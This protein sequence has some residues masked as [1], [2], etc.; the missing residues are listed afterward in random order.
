MLSSS[1]SLSAALFEKKSL[2]LSKKMLTF[3]YI[4]SEIPPSLRK[5]TPLHPG[6]PCFFDGFTQL[7]LIALMK[8][9]FKT[10]AKLE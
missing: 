4:E 8:R 3:V 5:K 2:H 1:R 10:A 7:Y 6:A 9:Y